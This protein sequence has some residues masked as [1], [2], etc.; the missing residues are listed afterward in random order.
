MSRGQTTEDD[1]TTTSTINT[2]TFLETCVLNADHKALEEHL[3]NS[4]VHRTDLNRCLLYGLQIVQQKVR[5]L[6][7]VAPALTLM[8]QSGAMW[9]SYVLLDNYKTPYHVICESPGDH[10]ELLEMM[11]NTSQRALIDIQDISEFTAALYAV[12]HAN[13]HCLNCLIS[14]GADLNKGATQFHEEQLFPITE[15]IK[16]F[17]CVDVH[18]SANVFDLLLDNGVEINNYPFAS[19]PI[20]IA[21]GLQNAYC[22]KE[23]IHNGA[24]LDMMDPCQRYV[25]ASIAR[26]GD[27]ELLECMFNNGIDINIRAPDGFCILDHVVAS[28]RIKAVCYLLDKGVAIPNYTPKVHDAQCEKCKENVLIL[29]YDN[30]RDIQ[31]SCLTAIHKSKLEIVMLLDEY[32]NQRCKSFYA[33]RNAVLF[34]RTEVVRYLLHK[35]AYPLNVKY[36]KCHTQYGCENGRHTLITELNLSFL[37]R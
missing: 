21:V 15:A 8:L 22:V 11:I 6:S 13:I 36:I 19:S 37:P 17:D 14:N 4:D 27:V 25:W 32:G 29:Q 7:H 31:D 28:D 9:N 33:L 2:Q 30:K 23:L 26:L 3:T 24:R 20:I 35:Y 10:H 5:E 16:N 34:G 1:V 12:R 18:T